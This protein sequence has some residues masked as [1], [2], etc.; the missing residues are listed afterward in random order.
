MCDVQEPGVLRETPVKV[1]VKRNPFPRSHVLADPTV[2]GTKVLWL[3][4]GIPTL[5]GVGHG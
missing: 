5:Q 1:S 4:Q 3:Q 2:K